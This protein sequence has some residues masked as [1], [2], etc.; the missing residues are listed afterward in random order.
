MAYQHVEDNLP[1]RVN[2]AGQHT[3]Q[4]IAGFQQATGSLPSSAKY[5]ESS[6]ASHMSYLH[7]V[8]QDISL[9]QAHSVVNSPYTYADSTSNSEGQYKPRTTEIN[10]HTSFVTSQ[11][12]ED[13]LPPQ[14]NQT[15]QPTLRNIAGFHQA[16]DSLPNTVKYGE[17]SLA[18]HMAYLPQDKP[19]REASSGVS[20]PYAYADST[21]YPGKQYE[22]HTTEQDY[23][24]RYQ[25][26][27]SV[28]F[29]EQE[30][31]SEK[32][33]SAP[34]SFSMASSLFEEQHVHEK[35]EQPH[36]T[37]HLQSSPNS[38]GVENT[39]HNEVLADDK[40]KP[41][42]LSQSSSNSMSKLPMETSQGTSRDSGQN[43][44]QH[45][46]LGNT[47]STHRGRSWTDGATT[48][49]SSDQ[50]KR[51]SQPSTEKIPIERVMSNDYHVEVAQHDNK[52]PVE[53]NY[54]SISKYFNSGG[55][56]LGKGGFGIVYEGTI[57]VDTYPLP[58]LYN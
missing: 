51:I 47:G 30:Q 13:N 41:Q 39:H 46:A 38:F 1:P 54:N 3:Q 31:S 8:P 7:V 23:A 14:V 57:M 42:D 52:C 49:T 9:R 32:D 48:D 2:Q 20:S 34:N 37:N 19:L 44:V 55:K 25:S 5:G 15:G 56:N 29:G 35:I 4:N 21:P 50:Q 24:S 33:Q 27:Y 58:L 40:I 36:L 45:E 12:V 28:P 53:M 43:K 18:S 17:N 10:Q 26:Q 22:P 6:L 11:H 16:T